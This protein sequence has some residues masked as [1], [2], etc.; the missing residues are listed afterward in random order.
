M[1][2]P[3][4]A[5][6]VGCKRVMDPLRGIKVESYTNILISFKLF[7]LLYNWVLFDWLYLPGSGGVF[8]GL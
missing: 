4:D 8:Q 3:S 7:L 1:N 6:V 5:Y 2:A